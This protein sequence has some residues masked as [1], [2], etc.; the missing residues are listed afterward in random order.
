MQVYGVIG[1]FFTLMFAAVQKLCGEDVKTQISERRREAMKTRIPGAT[2]PRCA[3]AH[4]VITAFDDDT[5]VNGV[6]TAVTPSRR[7]HGV[8][9]VTSPTGVATVS[10]GS[11]RC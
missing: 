2:T 5:G 4:G 7:H 6:V 8:N 3:D 11:S 1:L 9:L 10:T